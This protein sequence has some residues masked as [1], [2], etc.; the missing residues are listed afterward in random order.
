MTKQNARDLISQKADPNKK[1]EYN[2]IYQI[3][4]NDEVYKILNNHSIVKTR[5]RDGESSK[6]SLSIEC[7]DT[8]DPKDLIEIFALN[9]KFDEKFKQAIEGDGQEHKRIRTLH[10][11]ALL[12]LLCFYGVSEDKPLM[13]EFDNRNVSFTSSEFEVR[14]KVAH[15]LNG[16][17]HYSNIDVLL[18][19]KDKNGKKVKLFLESKFSEYLNWGKYSGISNEV[20]GCI[21]RKLEKAFDQMGLTYKD[22]ALC[23][24]QGYTRHYAGGIKQMISHFIGLKNEIENGKYPDADIYLGTILYEFPE[25]VDNE[26]KKLDDYKKAYKTLAKGLNALT[27]S[28]LKVLEECFTYQDIFKVYQHLD[29]KV[30][31]FYSSSLVS[32]KNL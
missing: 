21:Y 24:A 27:E 12:S 11:S 9:D 26:H 7:A 1:E 25:G 15:D 28:K 8:K 18:S 22:D 16:Q 17:P 14:N 6:K 30:K 29:E 3:F 20:Y 4:N 5:W 31:I 23:S 2:S 19:G 13:L 32:T 10:S